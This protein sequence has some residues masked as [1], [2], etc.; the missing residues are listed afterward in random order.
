VVEAATGLADWPM[1][2]AVYLWL[3]GSQDIVR[4]AE[5]WTPVQWTY[6]LFLP[7]VWVV[8]MLWRN[9]SGIR[10]W[11]S[12]RDTQRPILLWTFPCE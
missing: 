1:G 11:L 6:G 5:Y 4:A 9:A 7:E 12:I 3:G 10:I 8:H 2:Y